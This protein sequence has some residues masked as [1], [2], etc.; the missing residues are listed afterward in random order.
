MPSVSGYKMQ[1]R[2][3]AAAELRH[4]CSTDQL[5]DSAGVRKGPWTFLQISTSIFCLS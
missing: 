5:V 3:V 2:G 1:G 4:S